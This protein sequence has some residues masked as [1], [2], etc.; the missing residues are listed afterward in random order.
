MWFRA[1]YSHAL[2]FSKFNQEES[3]SSCSGIGPGVANVLVR[4]LRLALA[5]GIGASSSFSSPVV[6]EDSS[7]EEELEELSSLGMTDCGRCLSH[8]TSNS[9]GVYKNN[10][11]FSHC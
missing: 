4:V 9:S 6:Y 11:S 8:L 3:V 5:F 7:E 1:A 2:I 10:L